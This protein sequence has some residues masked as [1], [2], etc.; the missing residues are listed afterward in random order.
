MRIACKIKTPTLNTAVPY[1]IRY[2]TNHLVSVVFW[3][4][5]RSRRGTVS[6]TKEPIIFPQY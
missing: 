6:E 4:S 1:F 5:R 2:P 3:S